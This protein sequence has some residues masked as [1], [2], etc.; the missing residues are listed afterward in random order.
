MMSSALP[1]RTHTYQN[2]VFDSTYWDL[3]APRPDD[4]IITS[5]YKSGTTWTQNIVLQLIFWGQPVPALSDVSP[6]LE[7]RTSGI[8]PK[9]EKLNAQQHRRLIKSHLPLNALLYYPQVKYIV[10]GRDARDVFMSFWNHYSSFTDAT[11]A[12]LN[13]PNGR[14]GDPLPRCP[15]DIH[16]CWTNW[17]NR[18]WFAWESEGYP[19]SGNLA[20][21]QSWWIFRHLENI[22]FVHFNDLLHDLTSEIARIASYL[23]INL[24]AAAF[25]TIAQ[26]LSFASVK[27]YAAMMLPMP[28]EAA[29]NTWKQGSDAFFF[30]GTNGR[31]KEVLSEAELL[32]YEQAKARVLSPDS[33]QWLEQGR[34]ALTDH[35][36]R[37]SAH[38]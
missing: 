7:H 15:A 16:E 13:D 8:A 18:G 32:M 34:I 19:H 30:K 6:F 38:T 14:V 10:V 23:Q 33:A 35:T 29:Q 26:T 28:L 27:Q 5:S 11:Y 20:H 22:L 17:I 36:A 1:M 3:Y 25:S 9:I 31:W 37:S 2:H 4:I 24:P 21:T 12:R